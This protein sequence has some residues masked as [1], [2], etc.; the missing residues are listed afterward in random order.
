M[1]EN[2]M[3]GECHKSYSID[4]QAIGPEYFGFT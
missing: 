4:G 1:L 3:M 2:H